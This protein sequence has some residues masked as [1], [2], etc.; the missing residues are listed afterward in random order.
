MKKFN[1]PPFK[2]KAI[3]IGFT[4]GVHAVAIIGLLFLGMS[5]PPKPPKQI[6]TIL[7][8]PEDFWRHVSLW[9]DA[10]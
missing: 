8:R 1:K 5:E 6:K 2:Q 9:S 3:A 10:E 4:L 7:V